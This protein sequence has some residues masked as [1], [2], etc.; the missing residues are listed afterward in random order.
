MAKKTFGVGKAI[1]L[2][3]LVVMCLFGACFLWIVASHDDGNKAASTVDSANVSGQKPNDAPA[4]PKAPFD[5]A[6]GEGFRFGNFSYEVMGK[7]FRD[8]VGG[9]F[10]RVEASE[11]AVFV[12]VTLKETNL[13]NETQTVLADNLR[14]IDE[15]GRSFSPSADAN[16]AHAVSLPRRDVMLSQLQPGLARRSTVVFESPVDV[17][18]QI[19]FVEIP[20]RGI[21]NS[22]KRRV[23]LDRRDHY[24]LMEC[25]KGIKSLGTAIKEEKWDEAV[26]EALPEDR[27]RLSPD[28]LK[29]YRAAFRE[30]MDFARK[31]PEKDMMERMTVSDQ[32][33]LRIIRMEW[34]PLEGEKDSAAYLGV[35]LRCRYSPQSK[36]FHFSSFSNLAD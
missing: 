36:R 3:I 14:L 21:A 35:E 17:K 10:S 22:G 24:L 2:G 9:D 27:E 19:L 16:L 15:K 4:M 8:H 33:L 13:T 32:G 34:T 26:A 12:L 23:L 25:A 11:G 5:H 18:D 7:D 28:Y 6:L 29:T 1:L 20:E 30:Y 31:H